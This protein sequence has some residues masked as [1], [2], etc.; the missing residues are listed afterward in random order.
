MPGEFRA[1]WR[2]R[3]KT[4]KDALAGYLIYPTSTG[5]LYASETPVYCYSVCKAAASTLVHMLVER[6]RFGFET[7]VWPDVGHRRVVTFGY[8]VGEV[9]R[10]ITGEP[11]SQVLREELSGPLRLAGGAPEGDPG[12]VGPEI[13][14]CHIG[15][16]FARRPSA[17]RGCRGAHRRSGGRPGL[18]RLL[19]VPVIKSISAMPRN[20]L[21][22][23]KARAIAASVLVR[24]SPPCRARLIVASDRPAS[25]ANSR[26]VNP[27]TATCLSNPAVFKWTGMRSSLVKEIRAGCDHSVT[28]QRTDYRNPCSL[29][30]GLNSDLWCAWQESNLLPFGPEPNALSGELQ[31]R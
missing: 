22:R 21:S 13:D 2:P 24:S 6:G 7:M 23:T 16:V 19:G 27:R 4:S 1:N 3:A 29:N 17:A 10:R 25:R 26:I 30:I 14:R 8:I 18:T 15:Q 20:G 31:A 9:I 28:I 11:I 12:T 5:R